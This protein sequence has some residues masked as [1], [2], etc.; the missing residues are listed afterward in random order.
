MCPHAV[1][2]GRKNNSKHTGQDRDTAACDGAAA[3]LLLDGSRSDKVDLNLAV[4]CAV[5][6]V[7]VVPEKEHRL[8]LTTRTPDE[9]RDSTCS[10][11][12][13]LAETTTRD[14]TDLL[15]FERAVLCCERGPPAAEVESSRT[16]AHEDRRSAGIALTE[17]LGRSMSL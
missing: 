11:L 9:R 1:F 8:L 13:W 6:G 7:A 4:G 5:R 3:A 17:G 14:C 10:V 2:T 16:A 12:P 15:L